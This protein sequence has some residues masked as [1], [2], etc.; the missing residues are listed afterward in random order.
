[1]RVALLF[2][3]ATFP[4]VANA[5][6]DSGRYWGIFVFEST[7]TACVAIANQ[8]HD[9]SERTGIEVQAVSRDGKPLITWNSSWTPDRNGTLWRLGVRPEDPTPQVFIMDTTDKKIHRI[10]FGYSD[11]ENLVNQ[12]ESIRSSAK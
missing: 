9:F 2:I 11:I 3:L 6:A 4:F 8:V 1:M 5:S 7:C 10:S 12:F